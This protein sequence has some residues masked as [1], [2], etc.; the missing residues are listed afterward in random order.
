MGAVPAYAS[1]ATHDKARKR[2]DMKT[3]RIYTSQILQSHLVQQKIY[4]MV[5]V[6]QGTRMNRKNL[7]VIKLYEMF[8]TFRN[9]RNII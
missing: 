1:L 3:N 7:K 6:I 4:N 9:I 2:R 5:K 8:P